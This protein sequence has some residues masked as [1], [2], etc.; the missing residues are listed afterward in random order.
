VVACE[1]L[2]GEGKDGK[3]KR[4]EKGKHKNMLS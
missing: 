4:R 3:M 2:M 1:K